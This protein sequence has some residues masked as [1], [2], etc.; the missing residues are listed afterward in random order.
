MLVQQPL[1]LANSWAVRDWLADP[2][3]GWDSRSN[4]AE[5][6]KGSVAPGRVGARRA[7]PTAGSGSFAQML[8]DREMPCFYE[9]HFPRVHPWKKTAS[10]SQVVKRLHEMTRESLYSAWGQ[11]APSKHQLLLVASVDVVHV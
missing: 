6:I 11:Q 9:L 7:A 5:A 8:H 4:R 1:V 3:S 10:T 2:E